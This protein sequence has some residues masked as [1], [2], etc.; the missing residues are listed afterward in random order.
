[1][2]VREVI[3]YPDPRLREAAEPVRDFGP[4]LSTFVDDLLDTLR[5]TGGI[6]LSAPQLGDRRAVFVMDLSGD[7]TDPRVF[8]NPEILSD[9]RDAWVEE[10]CLS[11]PGVEAKVIRATRIRVRAQDEDGEFFEEDLEDMEA[12]CVQHEVDHLE[13]RLFIDRLSYF[14]RMRALLQA[15]RGARA[16]PPPRIEPASHAG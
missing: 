9:E 7:Y 4:D 2:S 1:M 12:V 16:A 3:R 5:P 11:L 8:V 15:R 13:G 14:K 10:S 6:G